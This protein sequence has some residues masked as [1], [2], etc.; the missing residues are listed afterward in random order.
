MTQPRDFPARMVALGCFAVPRQNAKP[1][2][3]GR[4][5]DAQERATAAR[6]IKGDPKRADERLRVF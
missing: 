1:R 2:T 5:M 3:L 6:M 4:K